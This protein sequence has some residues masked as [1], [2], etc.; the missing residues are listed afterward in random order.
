MRKK[1]APTND[2]FTVKKVTRWA[3]LHRVLA[4]T[5]H[6][7]GRMNAGDFDLSPPIIAFDPIAMAVKTQAGAIYQLAGPPEDHPLMRMLMSDSA[8]FCMDVSEQYW[9]EI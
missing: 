2:Y 7:Y 4:G 8:E 1:T 6:V 9:N 3:V 5:R